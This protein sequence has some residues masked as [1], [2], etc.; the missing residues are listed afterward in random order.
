M[1]LKPDF[2]SKAGNRTADDRLTNACTG[3]CTHL[4]P[5]DGPTGLRSA[6]SA[7][8]GA[9]QARIDDRFAKTDAAAKLERIDG[10]LESSRRSH[11]E[12]LHARESAEAELGNALV[13][14][15]EKKITVA[16]KALENTTAA[17]SVAAK[18]IELLQAARPDAERECRSV[19]QA[20]E[21]TVKRELIAELR[22]RASAARGVIL[23]ALQAADVSKAT[24]EFSLT[25]HVIGLFTNQT[26]HGL[27]PVAAATFQPRPESRVIGP[28]DG[29]V[30]S[31]A[32]QRSMKSDLVV[33]GA[34]NMPFG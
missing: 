11:D 1:N 29:R 7:A 13:G 6:A 9:H 14:T 28:A 3:L 30:P 17:V 21:E 34:D 31:P 5:I 2:T 24:A 25:T 12:A 4:I 18:E 33:K 19:R 27:D 10:R 32:A 22:Q 23:E 15:D 20:L 26:V 16:R 8:I